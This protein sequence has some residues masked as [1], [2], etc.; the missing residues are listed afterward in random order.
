M[1][2]TP[3]WITEAEVVSLIDLAGAIDAL[4]EALVMEA[5][6][7]AENMLKTHLMV[8]QNDAMHALGASIAGAGLAGTKT[9]VNV[10]GKSA[11]VLVLFS[12]E[13][14]SCQAV[15]EAMALGQM[16]TGAMTSVGTRYLAPRDAEEM[17]I[18]GAGKQAMTQVAACAAARPLKRLR[19]YSPTPSRRAVFADAA[20]AAFDFEVTVADTVEEAV[21]DAPIITLITNATE[22]YLRSHM[23]A[24]GAHV[25]AMGAI[26]PARV[27]FAPDIF[28]RCAAIVVDTIG[29]VRELSAEFRGYFGTGHGSWEEIKPISAVAAAGYERPS[30]ADLTL[31]KAVGMGISDLALGTK[32]LALARAEGLGYPLPER[33][34]T[35]PAV[36]AAN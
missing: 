31:F 13:D 28:P 22:P 3:V 20:R 24:P 26:V 30:D 12:L 36:R 35:A 6:D 21:R 10:G 15:I 2:D 8:G 11:P 27:E 7:E 32:I 33:V 23:V 9:W 18:I 14:G 17:A 34:R 1:T 25:N 16:R 29:G 19:V 5:R 4:E